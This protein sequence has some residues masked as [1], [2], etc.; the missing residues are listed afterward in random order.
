MPVS[1]AWLA[2]VQTSPGASLRDRL[3]RT[4]RPLARVRRLRG[5]RGGPGLPQRAGTA[6]VSVAQLF[7]PVDSAPLRGEV[8]KVPNRFEGADVAGSLSR[9]LWR[10][11][12]LLAPESG[13]R[14]ALRRGQRPQTRRLPLRGV[15]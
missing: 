14:L 15:C 12:Q 6:Q 4:R 1:Q 9:G 2:G 13:A 5:L 7:I 8:V 11:E 10:G 3:R